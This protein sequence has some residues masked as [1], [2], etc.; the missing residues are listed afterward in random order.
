ML[1]V[2]YPF[3][4]PIQIPGPGGGHAACLRTAVAAV[5][6]HRWQY[7]DLPQ[8]MKVWGLGLGFTLGGTHRYGFSKIGSALRILGI[9][10]QASGFAAS[11][12][13]FYRDHIKEF[14]DVYVLPSCVQVMEEVHKVQEPR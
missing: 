13:E 3:D 11:L 2:S 6:V 4:I 14:P 10:G 8:S 7:L 1:S 9:Q 12:L 5:S